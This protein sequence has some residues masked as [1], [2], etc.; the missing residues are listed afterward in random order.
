L[1]NNFLGNLIGVAT[2]PAIVGDQEQ[3]AI[4]GYEVAA[5]GIRYMREE[6]GQMGEVRGNTSHVAAHRIEHNFQPRCGIL[7]NGPEKMQRTLNA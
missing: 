3:H 2:Y 6:T 4:C 5:T 1:S 7:R